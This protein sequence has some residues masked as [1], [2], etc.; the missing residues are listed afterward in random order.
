MAGM[1]GLWKSLYPS[2]TPSFAGSHEFTL[3]TEPQTTHWNR[4]PAPENSG[5][6]WGT[7]PVFAADQ[8]KAPTANSSLSSPDG[9]LRGALFIGAGRGTMHL[10]PELS[11]RRGPSLCLS[12]V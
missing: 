8:H 3:H 6:T 10:S 12:G 7:G 11:V 4:P 5:Q 2:F 1:S 9:R